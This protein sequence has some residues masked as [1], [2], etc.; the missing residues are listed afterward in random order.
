MAEINNVKQKMEI[1]KPRVECLYN[2]FY[3][4]NTFLLEVHSIHHICGSGELQIYPCTNIQHTHTQKGNMSSA[5][6]QFKVAVKF[7][8]IP[9]MSFLLLFASISGPV[10]KLLF[11]CCLHVCL[12]LCVC[13]CVCVCA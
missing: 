7:W 13:V 6:I 10:C 12:Y 11:A 2:R 3:K 1:N 9:A 8:I 5:E 4:R